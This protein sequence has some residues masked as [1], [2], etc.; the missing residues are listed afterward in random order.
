MRGWGRSKTEIG[1]I[2]YCGAFG[3]N[4]RGQASGLAETSTSDPNGEDFCGFGTH[5]LRLAF[6]WQDG[7]MTPLQTLGGNNGEAGQINRRGE[8]AGNAENTRPDST[9]P[10]GGPQVLEE[11][12]VV[13]KKRL[14]PA[15]RYVPGRSGRLGLRDQRQG[16]GGRSVRHLLNP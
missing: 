10:P 15:A 13:W 12:P 14:R 7:M 1:N 11:K 4:E 3:V 2:S 6:L 8:V 5:L 16:P 9:C